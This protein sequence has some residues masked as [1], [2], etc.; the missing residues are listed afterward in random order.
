MAVDENA[1][2]RGYGSRI[3]DTLEAEARG[4]RVRKIVLNAR[5]TS[6]NSTRNAATKSLAMPKRYLGVVPH[7]HMPK[8]LSQDGTCQEDCWHNYARIRNMSVV[9]LNSHCKRK[10]K[11]PDEVI[12]KA[13]H[14][15]P[16]T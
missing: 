13:T 3:L 10:P 7:V 8:S 9:L 6:W 11:D 4:H 15:N 5:D 2:G 12:F 1:R 14:R 16:S